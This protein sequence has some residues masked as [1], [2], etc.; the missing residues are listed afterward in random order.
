MYKTNFCTIEHREYAERCMSQARCLLLADHFFFLKLIC[1]TMWQA[2]SVHSYH[3]EINKWL[4]IDLMMHPQEALRSIPQML[5]I[6]IYRFLIISVFVPHDKFPYLYQS[7]SICCFSSFRSFSIFCPNLET[8]HIVTNL[9]CFLKNKEKLRIIW[10]GYNT[11]PRTSCALAP[12]PAPPKVPAY[13]LSF[14]AFLFS[15][16][17]AFTLWKAFAAVPPLV[18]AGETSVVVL[19]VAAISASKPASTFPASSA[20][21]TAISWTTFSASCNNSYLY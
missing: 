17:S 14:A 18:V 7:T 15:H 21:C 5:M 3:I 8:F 6:I 12:H 4:R 10:H 16:S 11:L 19:S 2:I 9:F 13:E 1:E 20:S